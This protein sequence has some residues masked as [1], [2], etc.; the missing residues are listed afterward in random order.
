MTRAKG[1]IDKTTL[2][3]LLAIQIV[4]VGVLLAAKSGGIEEPEPFLEFDADGV[5]SLTVSNSEGS[6]S[7]S[8]VDGNW[9]LP[10]GVPAA[11]FKVDSVLERFAKAAGSWPV[12]NTAPTRERFEVTEENHQRHI[13]AKAGD[14]TVADIYL[15]TSP[16]YRKTHARRTGEDEIYTVTF[17]N[18]EAGVKASDWLDRSLLRP[19]GDVSGLR[20]LP[21][22]PAPAVAPADPASEA[23]TEQDED[24]VEPVAG[25]ELSKKEDDVWV[26]AEEAALDQGKVETF[27]GRFKG[28]SVTGLHEAALPESATMTFVLTDDEGEQTLSVF[29]LD[30]GEKYVAASDRLPGAYEL[31]KYIAEQMN[32]PF[33]DLLP[34]PPEDEEAEES[35]PAAEAEA[36]AESE[37][38]EENEDTGAAE[39][40]EDE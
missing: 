19:K 20:R 32:K 18:Y 24:T 13:V 37:S 36:E 9:Q 11:G 25:F 30:D 26:S 33:A 28:L 17:S 27:V 22:D 12:A 16:G 2:G 23:D 21:G 5:D 6:V 10:D 1:M 3:A 15:G 34:D 29:S 7:L 40:S 35:E 14:D 4:F 8:K 31:S 38:A 39:G